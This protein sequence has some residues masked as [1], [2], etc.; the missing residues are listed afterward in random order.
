MH[1]TVV[2]FDTLTIVLLIAGLAIPIYAARASF[3]FLFSNFEPPPLMARAL[4]FVPV[5][6]FVSLIVPEL[7]V[8]SGQ[9]DLSL[10]NPKLSAGIVA[11]VVAWTTRSTLATLL[12]GMAAF[13]GIQW[14]E[15]LK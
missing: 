1:S 2:S 12:I 8:V 3:I 6:V 15:T 9:I 14:L 7:I 5:S 4:R 11:A 10:F 13:H